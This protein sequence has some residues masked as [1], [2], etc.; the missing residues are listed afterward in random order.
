MRDLAFFELSTLLCHGISRATEFQ[1]S[2]SRESQ[3]SIDESLLGNI[4]PQGF[5]KKFTAS[6]PEIR[7]TGTKHKVFDYLSARCAISFTEVTTWRIVDLSSIVPI[8]LNPAHTPPKSDGRWLAP[9]MANRSIR[10]LRH[11]WRYSTRCIFVINDIAALLSICVGI[12]EWRR[13]GGSQSMRAPPPFAPIYSIN[14]IKWAIKGGGGL[15]K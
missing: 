6:K 14:Q 10:L 11:D 7:T 9:S 2:R 5:T 3:F 8:H 12:V 4:F 15:T 1:D 13:F